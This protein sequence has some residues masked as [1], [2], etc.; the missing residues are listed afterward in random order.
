MGLGQRVAGEEVEDDATGFVLE[1]DEVAMAAALDD[2]QFRPGDAF[3]QERGVG[4][5]VDL[6]VAAVDHESWGGDCGEQV[7]GVVALAGE[8]VEFLGEFGDGVGK[9]CPDGLDVVGPRLREGRRDH[10]F[11]EEA[12]A[13]FGIGRA[14]GHPGIDS[15]RAADAVG[16]ARRCA[17]EDK[18][19]HA[20]GVVDTEPLA[21]AA[22]HRDAIGVGAFNAEVVEDGDGVASEAA[23]GVGGF[24]GLIAP[25][26]AAVVEHDDPVAGA[27]ILTYEVPVGVVAALPGDEQERFAGT[28][29]FEVEAGAVGGGEWHDGHGNGKA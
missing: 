8:V 14:V 23:G 29:F 21:D 20:A 4:G 3:G 18:R 16:V 13:L 19:A 22:A 7:P 5:G 9:A 11:E 2:V 24:A 10:L 6:I 28:K 25:A 1:F 15:G 12:E 26:G 27:E 17:P